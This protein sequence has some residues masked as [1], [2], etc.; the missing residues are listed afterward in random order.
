MRL[1]Q[2]PRSKFVGFSLA[3][4]LSLPQLENQRDHNNVALK[5]LRALEA[6]GGQAWLD[7]DGV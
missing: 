3:L 6:F 1:C 4:C 5:A 7:K 2:I